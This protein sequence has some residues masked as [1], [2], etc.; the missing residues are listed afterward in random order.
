MK[1]DLLDKSPI[2]S[3]YHREWFMKASHGIFSNLRS[4]LRHNI[5]IPRDQDLTVAL[6]CI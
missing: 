6:L 1:K 5:G 3:A 4:G 2:I